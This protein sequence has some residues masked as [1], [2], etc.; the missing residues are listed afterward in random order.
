MRVIGILA[1][2]VN[3]PRAVH[4]YRITLPF[5]F[6]NKEEKHT[7]GW[8]D[9]KTSAI[10]LTTDQLKYVINSD[11]ITLGRPIAKDYVKVYEYIRFL[12]SKG[13]RVVYET[14]DDLT[15]AYRDTSSGEGATCI[16]YLMYC[17]AVT[18]TTP[19]LKQRV[20]EFTD[21]PVYCI[22]NYVEQNMFRSVSQNHKREFTGTTNI[23]LIGTPT[24][25]NDWDLAY[26]A[27]SRIL[28]EYND[29]RLLIGGFKPKYVVDNEKISFMPF[30]PYS[31]YPTMI[32]EADIVVAAIDP[33]DPFNHCKSAVKA[34]ESW[35]A[36]R[37]IGNTIGGAAVVATES[38]VYNP[39]V[40]HMRN[41]I[42]TKH[43][44]DEYY[45]SIKTLIDDEFLRR[46]L[47]RRG[48]LDGIQRHS[49][50]SSYK[51]WISVYK[52]ILRS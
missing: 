24:H 17:D 50:A 51:N 37:N 9:S 22:N 31:A 48:Y 20:S 11:I 6:I 21:K 12:K 40:T 42:L 16:P 26:N 36:V 10:N 19:Y 38:V 47:Q 28:D 15:E 34:M 32:A 49:I 30:R 18:V 29:V 44:V 14:D 8:V 1:G 39:V 3:R 27:I 41:G 25:E 46:K 5:S 35:A 33:D 7:A 52:K 43:S 4:I 2:A 13:A 23:L 45:N